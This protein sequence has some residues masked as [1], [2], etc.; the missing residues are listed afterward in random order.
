ML[1]RTNHD[2]TTPRVSLPATLIGPFRTAVLLQSGTVPLFHTDSLRYHCCRASRFVKLTNRH[3]LVGGD[4]PEDFE[5]YS[6]IKPSK[7][8]TSLRLNVCVRG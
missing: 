4:V 8:F 1:Q 6:G 5:E 3:I 2:V 7:I